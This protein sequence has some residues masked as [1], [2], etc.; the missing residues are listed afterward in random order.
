M[1]LPDERFRSV[2]KTEEF[3]ESLLDPKKTPRVPKDIRQ[4]ARCCLRHYPS[5]HNMKELERAAPSV[6][7]E[8]MEDVNRMIKYWEE[9]KKFTNET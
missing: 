9:G 1:T 5:Y 8:R 2:L 7:Q 3:L 4:Q 6:V